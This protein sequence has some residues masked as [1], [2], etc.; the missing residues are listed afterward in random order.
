MGVLVFY[1]QPWSKP[2]LSKVEKYIKEADIP[3]NL[4]FFHTDIKK[5]NGDIEVAS[6]NLIG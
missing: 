2:T 5:V 3:P 1:S 4:L 6:I